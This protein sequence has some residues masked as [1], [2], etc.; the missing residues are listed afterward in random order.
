MIRT[1]TQQDWDR[2]REV[3]IGQDEK[4]AMSVLTASQIYTLQMI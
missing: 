4:I 2:D 1:G 3:V